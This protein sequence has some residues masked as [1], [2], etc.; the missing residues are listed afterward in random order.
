MHTDTDVL[1]IGTGFAGLGMAIRMLK[2]GMQDFVVLEQAD[3][4]GGTWRDN[5]YPGVACD[6]PSHLYSFSFEPNPRWSQFFAPQSEIFAYMKHCTDKYGVRP[7]IHFNAEVVKAT[8]DDKRGVWDVAT[9]NG[10]SY[11][12]KALVSGSGGLSK[13]SYPD[14]PGLDRFKGKKVH[15]ARWDHDYPLEGKRVAVIGTGASSIQ[16][17]PSIVDRVGHLSLFQ[18]TPPWVLPKPDFKI[19]RKQQAR[20]AKSPWIQRA[21]RNTIYWALESRALGFSGMIPGMQVRAERQA[22]KHLEEQVKDPVLRAKLTPNYRFGCKR[23]L[24]SNEYYA[25]LQKPN[26][27]V[28][29]DGIQEVREHSIVTRDGKEHEVDVIVCATGFQAAEAVAPFELRGRNG[30]DLNDAWRDGAEA[31]LGTAVSGFPNMFLLVGPNSGLGHNSMVHMIESQINY[32]AESLKTLRERGLASIEVKASAQTA[33]NKKLV[34][35]LN[36]TVWA[37]GGCV[38]WYQT[39]TGK[40]TTLWPGFTFE[41]RLRTRKFDLENYEAHLPS[42]AEPLK[43]VP[44]SAEL[45]APPAE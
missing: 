25:A 43:P 7:Y 24:I 22:R 14:I 23:L 45:A 6:I 18:R 20:L 26:A 29:T 10:N 11:R 4:V 8:F 28:V 38:S 36:R 21:I 37:T 16:L 39:K 2:D 3:E 27:S 34:E 5:H 42:A 40:N 13:P 19:G 9:R 31:Y 15:S 33:Y 41:Y 30:V 1:I 44:A 12:T 17:V 32:V 35:R